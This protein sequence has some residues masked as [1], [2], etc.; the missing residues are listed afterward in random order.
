MNRQTVLL[1]ILAVALTGGAGYFN[2]AYFSE[3]KPKENEVVAVPVV[4]AA[5]SLSVSEPVHAEQLTVESWPSH[6]VPRGSFRKV[7]AVVSRIP[8]RPF[9]EGEPLLESGLSQK[10]AKGGLSPLISEGMRAMSVRVDQVIAIAGFVKPGSSVDVLALV[11]GASASRS[12][13]RA[14]SQIIIENVRVLAVDQK[15]DDVHAYSQKK[16]QKK[17]QKKVQR[18]VGIVTLQVTPTQAQKLAFAARHGSIQ[19]ALRNPK[20]DDSART[21]SVDVSHL[22]GT[23]LSGV[24]EVMKG[25]RVSSHS[26]ESSGAIR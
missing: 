23:G 7:S 21:T 2:W 9:W 4:M 17:G 11:K 13:S 24:V 18:K 10:G 5:V 12:K 22:E 6:L 8:R 14:F 1:S 15:L 3:P 19:L 16:G 26:F 20:D 25:P